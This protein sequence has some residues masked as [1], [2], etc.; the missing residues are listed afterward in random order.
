MAYDSQ[1]SAVVWGGVTL[2]EVVA[3]DATGGSAETTEATPLAQT[4]RVKRFKVGDIDPGTVSV[5]V[6]SPFAISETN[7]GLTATLSI[8]AS[9]HSRSWP[10]AMLNEPRWRGQTNEYQEYGLTFKLGG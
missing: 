5:V 1:G 3:F 2:G 4:S 8:T 6:R 7:V 10:W 9:G